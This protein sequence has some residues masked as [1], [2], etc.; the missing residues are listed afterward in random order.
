MGNS[1]ALFAEIM[2][3]ILAIKAAFDRNWQNIWIKCDSK[4]ATLAVKSPLIVP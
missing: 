4:L 3:V 1:N 2:E